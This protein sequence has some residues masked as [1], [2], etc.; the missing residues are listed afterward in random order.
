[1]TGARTGGA[2][3]SGVLNSGFIALLPGLEQTALYNNLTTAALIQAAS[4]TTHA[5]MV[6]AGL[7]TKLAPFICPSDS[8]ASGSGTNQ[9]RTS[10]RINLGT[11]GYATPDSATVPTFTSLTVTGSPSSLSPGNGPFKITLNG[12]ATSGHPG[13]GFS[14][15]LF[16]T[17]KRVF[18]ANGSGAGVTDVSGGLFASGYPG[19]T[20]VNTHAKPGTLSTT[21]SAYNTAGG[22]TIPTTTVPGG[23]YASSFHTNGVNASFG[24]GAG[25]FINYSTDAGLWASLG[26]AAGGEA[27]T[28]P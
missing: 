1:M 26:T 10:Y 3:S 12:D 4:L 14:N 24:D 8:E 5:D 15:T 21:I 16:F 27:A 9:S 22:V 17:E 18:K 28:P 25:K 20:G 6:S 11:G 23:I 13:D 2:A 19:E 7:N